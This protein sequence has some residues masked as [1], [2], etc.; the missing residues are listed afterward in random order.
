MLNSALAN[1]MLRIQIP[2][3]EFVM[4]PN[5]CS[6]RDRVLDIFLFSFSCFLVI[7]LLRNALAQMLFLILFLCKH[8]SIG[9]PTYALSAYTATSLALIWDL[10]WTLMA[11]GV[12]KDREIMPS[13]GWRKSRVP[14]GAGAR[15]WR[16]GELREVRRRN[17]ERPCRAPER[18]GPPPQKRTKSPLFTRS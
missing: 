15:L 12:Q 9:S 18:G 2:F 13:K 14:G 10:F 4:N 16:Q 3:I 7:G 8:F 11:K 17:C 5:M 6:I 1:P